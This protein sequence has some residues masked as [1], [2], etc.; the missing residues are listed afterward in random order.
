[1]INGSPG[2]PSRSAFRAQPRTSTPALSFRDSRDIFESTSVSASR[3]DPE[4]TH[5][6]AEAVFQCPAGL[7]TRMRSAAAV[8][9][10]ALSS[11]IAGCAVGSEKKGL[12][13]YEDL[14]HPGVGD[15]K[16][17]AVPLQNH[18]PIRW[19]G[20]RIKPRTEPAMWLG[21]FVGYPSGERGRGLYIAT[22]KAE[23]IDLIGRLEAI[24]LAKGF[25]W[26]GRAERAFELGRGVSGGLILGPVAGERGVLSRGSLVLDASDVTNVGYLSS[27]EPTRRTLVTGA[28]L[29]EVVWTDGEFA[30]YEDRTISGML[31]IDVTVS[32]QD[33]EQPRATLNW[34]RHLDPRRSCW[35]SLLEILTDHGL[36]SRTGGWIAWE[37][38]GDSGRRL[39]SGR[40]ELQGTPLDRSSTTDAVFAA[41]AEVPPTM[42]AVRLR[43]A[44]T[45][46]DRRVTPQ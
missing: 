22:G 20:R 11:L 8:V 30:W 29:G 39:A 18:H 36:F 9:L 32:I 16:L 34:N 7:C 40:Q 3:S 27:S 23:V 31:E 37:I 15:R 4:V 44:F 13:I 35:I 45:I 33:C 28:L 2:R 10:W 5:W 43:C 1:M 24:G 38:A 46:N 12:E 26:E 25:A 42:Q 19:V 21:S 14:H 17:V 6:A 41:I